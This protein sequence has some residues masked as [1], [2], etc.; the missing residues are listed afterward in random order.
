VDGSNFLIPAA[1]CVENLDRGRYYAK[2]YVLHIFFS[3]CDT[4]ILVA[5][6]VSHLKSPVLILVVTAD[7]SPLDDRLNLESVESGTEEC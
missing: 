5:M 6:N 2:T 4:I 7:T 1:G 3:Y